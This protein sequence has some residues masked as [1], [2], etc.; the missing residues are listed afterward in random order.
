MNGKQRSQRYFGVGHRPKRGTG[1]WRTLI[2]REAE[3]IEK[4]GEDAISYLQLSPPTLN[5]LRNA[6]FKRISELVAIFS[7]DPDGAL[8]FARCRQFGEKK[9]AELKRNLER[10][11]EQ[12]GHSLTEYHQTHLDESY[13]EN[14]LDEEEKG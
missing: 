14:L 11:L 10:Y 8:I 3:L 9:M 13:W 7:R 2:R 6:G 4:C 1:N 5:S 12:S